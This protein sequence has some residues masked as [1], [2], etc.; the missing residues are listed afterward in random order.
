MP[1]DLEAPAEA[2]AI[3]QGLQAR[4][5][6][7][8]A[9]LEGM[10]GV[11]ADDAADGRPGRRP[12]QRQHVIPGACLCLPAGH[13]HR[14][15]FPV[16]RRIER[17]DQRSGAVAGEIHARAI[18]RDGKDV[19]LMPPASDADLEGRMPHP[20]EVE[21][22]QQH[23]RQRRRRRCGRAHRRQQAEGLAGFGVALGDADHDWPAVHVLELVVRLHAVI[24]NL[25]P[26]S[27][28]LPRGHVRQPFAGDVVP[29]RV[30][31]QAGL[32]E[33]VHP[34][35]PP[36]ADDEMSCSVD[37][38]VEHLRLKADVGR[39]GVLLEVDQQRP[40][41]GVNGDAKGI[42]DALSSH[43]PSTVLLSPTIQGKLS[44]AHRQPGEFVYGSKRQG[45]TWSSG[46]VRGAGAGQAPDRTWP[47]AIAPRRP[48]GC[49]PRT[50]PQ[51]DRLW[52]THG[53]YRPQRLQPL[54]QP[55]R[56]RRR[57][58][59]DAGTAARGGGRARCG[60]R[61]AAGVLA[62]LGLEA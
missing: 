46:Q 16:E 21:I 19:R 25:I 7:V 1:L 59:G 12:I 13:C 17:G 57:R 28:Q 39:I 50:F 48:V 9:Q 34:A 4:E 23:Q 22:V 38:I 52:Y 5:S 55:L 41:H 24:I 44:G 18:H 54:P 40:R 6:R 8:E 49:P 56:E 10:D 61:P 47:A 37:R 30:G 2:G 3:F 35:I 11:G 33:H 51:K 53:A 60:R 43:G 14:F 32:V 62:K 36:P 15:E 45:A 20:D 27:G 29:G 42:D 26:C 58:G 31:V